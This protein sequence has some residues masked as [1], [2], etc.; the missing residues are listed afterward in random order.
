MSFGLEQED[1]S[2]I[3]PMALAHP[4]DP[5][6]SMSKNERRNLWAG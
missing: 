6:K 4:L 1:R 2:L 3:T 5:I